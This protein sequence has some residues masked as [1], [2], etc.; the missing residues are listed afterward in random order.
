MVAVK[1]HYTVGRYGGDSQR[2]MEGYFQFYIPRDRAPEQYAEADA[3]CWDSG[4]WNGDGPGI[5]WERWDYNEPLTQQ[6]LDIGRGL[7]QWL[8]TEWGFPLNWYD[9]PRIQAWNGYINHGSLASRGG[10]ANHTDGILSHEWDYMGVAA[11]IPTEEDDMYFMTNPANRTEWWCVS[12]NC[13]RKMT[14]SETNA[15]K[16]VG[17]KAFDADTTWFN[18]LYGPPV[19]SGDLTNI[20]NAVWTRTARTLS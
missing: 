4:D 3:W 5:E 8:H 10:L 15:M 14:I 1:L 20:A 13:K 17:K 6:Q 18:S 9:G 2:G 11:T 7:I 16:F 12:G 19:N